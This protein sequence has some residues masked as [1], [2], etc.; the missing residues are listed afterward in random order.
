MS[1]ARKTVDV[2]TILAY[3]NGYLSAK[4]G[5]V[6]ARRAIINMLEF[7]LFSVNRYRGYNYLTKDQLANPEDRPGVKFDNLGVDFI[8][9]DNT[10]RR[11]C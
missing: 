3:A 2:E 11:Y 8:N 6:E 1:N 9:T 5:S 4:E 10:R 7:A